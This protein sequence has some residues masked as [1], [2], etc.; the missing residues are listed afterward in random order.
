[1]FL[2]FFNLLVLVML[3]FYQCNTVL[4]LT[5]NLWTWF[6]LSHGTAVTVD[7]ICIQIV[8]TG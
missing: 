6:I 5:C 2:V 8:L 3:C 1:M 4:L 7:H